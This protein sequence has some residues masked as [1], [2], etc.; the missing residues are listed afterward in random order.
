MSLFSSLQ[1]ASNTLLASQLGLQVVGN[2]IANANTPGYIRQQINLQPQAPQRL[3]DLTL[4]L[5]VQVYSIT[6]QIDKFLE[7]RLRNA[8]SDVANGEAQESVYAQLESIISELGDTDLSS[9]L[10]RFFNSIH[11]ILNQPESVSVRNIAV[12]E[13]KT[14]THDIQL[15]DERVRTLREDVNN[16]IT[17]AA[18]EI[19]ALLIQVAELNVKI[20]QTEGGSVSRSDA[21]GLRDERSEVLKK[22]ATMIDVQ[23]EEQPNG[24]VS[25][26]LQGEYVVFQAV[27]RDLTVVLGTDR[28]Q[29]VTEIR[30]TETD[31]PIQTSSGKLAGLLAARDAILGGFV[32]QLDSFTR[33]LMNEFNK[34]Y[35]GGQGLTGYSSLTSEFAVSD[36]QAALDQAGLNFTPVNGSF[37]VKVLNKQTGLTSTRD[38][39]VDLNGLDEDTTLES[40]V[41]QLDA[42]DGISVAIDDTRNVE[43][44]SDSPN[45]SF[46]FAND[47]SGALAALGLNTF[48]SGTGAGDI[49]INSVVR[50]DPAKFAASKGGIDQDSENAE[51][52]ASLLTASLTS[53]NGDSLAVLYDSITSD[54]AQGA[55]VSK[56]VAEGYRTFHGS[57]EGQHLSISGVS[58][59]EEA[60]RMIA[61]QRMF[62]ASAKFIATINELL[63]MLVNL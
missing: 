14:L 17:A 40:L 41:S 47:T 36:V 62:Q 54:V 6:Q 35:S 12:L 31:A 1:I 27:H 29:A 33:V 25:V 16:Q 24:D 4:G 58:I 45:V 53:Q 59:D 11:D 9:S 55:S 61:F 42:I 30:F 22:L 19:N 34:I 15:L 18:D 13:G 48:F 39:L 50:S 5:G 52:L 56:S 7:A 28:G 63:E 46:S 26:F 3:G 37:Q 8:T 10:S 49:G 57:L 32:D 38:I 60:V 51:Q 20:V 2:N 21:V 43:I 44:T 23:T